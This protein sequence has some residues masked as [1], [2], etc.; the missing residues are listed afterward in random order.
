MILEKRYVFERFLD[1]FQVRLLN[2]LLLK[3]SNLKSPT[4]CLY[5]RERGKDRF[6]EEDNFLHMD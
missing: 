1:R 6:E 5:E 4:Q 2:P 3:N